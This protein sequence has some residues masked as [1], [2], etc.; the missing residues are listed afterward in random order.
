MKTLVVP[1]LATAALSLAS[2][3]ALAVEPLDT[4][5]VRL[6]GY[7]QTFDTEVRA[8]GQTA[9]GTQIDLQ[10]D[11]GI[12]EDTTIG[13]ASVS[14]RPWD[15]HEFGLSY[16]TTDGDATRILQRDIM[17]GATSTKHRPPSV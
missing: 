4:F 16:Y 1:C 14:W 5:S 6:G 2:F 12:D 11:L 10:R 8:D 7:V 17:F 3:P 15:H 13:Y 9:A